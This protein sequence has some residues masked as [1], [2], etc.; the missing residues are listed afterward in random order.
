[1]KYFTYLSVSIVLLVTG[2]NSLKLGETY[3][4]SKAGYSYVP[5]EPSQVAIKCINLDGSAC[6][7]V[8]KSEFLKA[9][10]DNSVR[11]ATREISG[12]VE[13]SI[14][15]LGVNI[16]TEGSSYEVIIDFV[17]SQTITRKFVGKWLVDVPVWVGDLNR[18]YPFETSVLVRY[19]RDKFENWALVALP[20]DN[21]EFG[22]SKEGFGKFLE[23]ENSKRLNDTVYL[24]CKDDVKVS[25]AEKLASYK[26]DVQISPNEFNIPVY[27]G[28][29]L[30]LKATVSVIQGKVNLGSLPAL[31]AAVKAGKA[32]GT[33]SVQTLGISGKS[34]RNNLLL[35][36]KIDDTTIQNA[37]QVLASIKSSIESDDT[38]LTPRILGFHNTIGAD[39]QG[40]NLIHSM[41]ANDETIELHVDP[42]LRTND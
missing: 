14:S 4:E 41:L 22:S 25:E 30:R 38:V 29:G 21:G 6:S 2:C 3:A 23:N 37:I 9:L 15:S 27:V 13:T 16:G 31:S 8:N 11:I 1:M 36:D 39:S 40:V 18:C 34:A 7:S 26:E 5:I 17:N 10:P 12:S 33:M 19:P 42:K 32:T 28:I 35:L 24:R 20:N